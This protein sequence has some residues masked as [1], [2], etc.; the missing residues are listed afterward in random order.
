MTS[1]ADPA[2][3]L[4]ELRNR[5]RAAAEFPRAYPRVLTFIRNNLETLLPT[6]VA[7]AKNSGTPAGKVAARILS[8]VAAP[9]RNFA[10]LRNRF[11]AVGEFPRAY[12]RVLTFIRNN[13]ETLLPLVNDTVDFQLDRRCRDVE[14][15]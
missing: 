15:G 4:A 1:F 13:L 8:D 3:S 14:H 11:R 2:R 5:F 6:V 9:A 12:P 7:L 10:E